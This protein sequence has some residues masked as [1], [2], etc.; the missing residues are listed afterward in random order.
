MNAT[1][2]AADPADEYHFLERPV[3]LAMLAAGAVVLFAFLWPT[4][5][6]VIHWLAG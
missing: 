3:G 4:I 2:H 6:P 5:L 1:T